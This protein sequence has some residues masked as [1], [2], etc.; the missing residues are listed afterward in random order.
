MTS[1][2]V[3]AES[4]TQPYVDP[5]RLVPFI[6]TP[7]KVATLVVGGLFGDE[8]KGKFVSYL[9]QYA[10]HVARAGVGTNAGHT[11]F[12]NGVQYKLRMVPSG[13]TNPS[14]K[15]YIGKGVLVDDGVLTGEVEKLDE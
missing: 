9:A 11:I 7:P 12:F 5:N 10:L 2:L 6:Y 13:F 1:S 4:R 14:A 3:I 8:G 15:L